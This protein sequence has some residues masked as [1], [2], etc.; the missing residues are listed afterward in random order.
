MKNYPCE[1]IEWSFFWQEDADRD[2]RRVLL[3]GDSIVDTCKR[4]VYF[5]L[6][7]DGVAVSAYVTSKGINSPF[8]L[9]E[10]RL[11]AAQHEG[12]LDAVFFMYGGHDGG[13]GAEEVKEKYS[14]TVRTLCD[15]FPSSRVLLSTFTA[16]TKGDGTEGTFAAPLTHAITFA[17]YNTFVVGVNDAARTTARDF[18]LPLLDAYAEMLPHEGMKLS[19]GIHFNGEGSKILAE[20][21]AAFLRAHL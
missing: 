7:P 1:T 9:P 16:V 20:K 19:D 13:M 11:L 18:S 10:L 12:R 6:A 8:Y 3:V 4:D 21:I 2:V 14:A 5:A 15:L 17:Q